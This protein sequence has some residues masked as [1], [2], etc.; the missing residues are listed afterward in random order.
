MSDTYVNSYTYTNIT[1]KLSLH[2]I[3]LG[4]KNGEKKQQQQQ[5]FSFKTELRDKTIFNINPSNH[6]Y[7]KHFQI[8]PS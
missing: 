4:K 5:N 7:L 2:T 6:L 8:S 3:F 1:S